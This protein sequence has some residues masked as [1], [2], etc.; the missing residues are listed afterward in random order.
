MGLLL[1]NAKEGKGEGWKQFSLFRIKEK[2]I[3][4]KREWIKLRIASV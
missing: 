1:R 2:G 4:R 3:E